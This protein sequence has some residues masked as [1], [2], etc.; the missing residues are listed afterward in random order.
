LEPDGDDIINAS[1]IQNQINGFNVNTFTSEDIVDG[2]AG[3]DT[4]IIEETGFW[5]NKF[6][7][8]VM[9]S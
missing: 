9:Y 3:F 2:G 8:W 6:W 4:L 7:R 1:V 5:P